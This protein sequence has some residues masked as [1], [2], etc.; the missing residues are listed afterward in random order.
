MKSTLSMVNIN[1]V[2][3]RSNFQWLTVKQVCVSY[4]VNVE[5]HDLMPITL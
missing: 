2:G 5:P 1:S 4:C 3:G